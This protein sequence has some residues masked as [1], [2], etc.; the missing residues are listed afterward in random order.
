MCYTLNITKEEQWRQLPW[1]K[2]DNQIRKI[3]ERIYD[4][5]IRNDSRSVKS[6]QKVLIGL[7]PAK[8]IA[9]RRISQNNIGKRAVGVDGIVFL[10]PTQRIDLVHKLK[11][12]GKADSI[13]KIFITKLNGI[14]IPL[15]IPTMQDSAK[16]FL[17][18]MALE[19]EWEARFE[20]NSYGFR[21]GRSCQ[22]AREA[23]YQ[24]L[25]QKAKYVF[26]ANI[27]S[28][29]PTIAHKSLLDKL[30][31]I[32][33]FRKQIHS[34]LKAG[35]TF[36]GVTTLSTGETPYG[37]PISPLL[38]NVALHGLEKHVRE[39][40]ET[41]LNSGELP[42]GSVPSNRLIVRYADNFV[43]IYPYLEILERIL[44]KV[45]NWLFEIGLEISRHNSSIRHTLYNHNGN[46]VGFIFLG[47]YFS[48]KECGIGKTI[49]FT[50]KNKKVPLR[51]SLQQKPDK[52]TVQKHIDKVRDIVKRMEKRPQEELITLLKPIIRGL[53]NY[54]AFTDNAYT[55]QYCNERIFYRLMRYSCNRHKSK[56][57]KWIIT[58]Y[59]R[60]FEGRKWIFKTPNHSSNL[61][62]Y[63]KRVW[64]NKYVKVKNRKS[65]YDG[66]TKYWSNR[67][68]MIA[69]PK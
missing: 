20:P 59:F 66:D 62:L 51:Y 65:P 39:C 53:T 11:I 10:T 52:G 57:K 69:Y 32:P 41:W 15:S 27:D 44:K 49:W 17:L 19:P 36:E 6:L 2:F 61:K 26:N 33:I 23:I 35:I 37:G 1:S 50:N 45:E 8:F 5:S 56:S 24:T 55:F 4:A 25:K 28:W 67:W 18:L 47:F 42:K 31:T 29:F 60:T 34:W 54:Y 64:R 21:P 3:Q 46:N 14:Q 58:K 12:D 13:R 40:L 68:K 63:S 9:V 7:T 16:Q 38:V 48:H 43:I 22:D 30:N